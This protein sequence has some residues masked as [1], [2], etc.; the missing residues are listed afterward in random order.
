MSSEISILI[1]VQKILNNKTRFICIFVFS[2]R[3]MNVDAQQGKPVHSLSGAAIK[4]I[5]LNNYTYSTT[6]KSKGMLVYKSKLVYNR[7]SS[8]IEEVS[9]KLFSGQF[10][11]DSNIYKYSKEEKLSERENYERNEL[12]LK[13]VYKYNEQLKPIEIL[14]YYEGKPGGKETLTYDKVGTNTG[15][16]QYEKDGRMEFF[17]EYIY[18][19][20]GQM[21][22]EIKYRKDSSLWV[23]KTYSYDE[24]QNKIK[25]A[26]DNT[27]YKSTNLTLWEFDAKG[28][29]TNCKQFFDGKLATETHEGYD[30]NG[31]LITYSYLAS[32]ETIPLKKTLGGYKYNDKGD[33]V[34]RIQFNAKGDPVAIEERIIEYY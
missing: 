1:I 23:R 13:T 7:N 18:N 33:W 11:V 16:V 5:V 10:L 19:A 30:K 27:Y 6:N 29:Q 3:F 25:E 34:K 17:C 24:H 4:S 2:F 26:S 8:V 20:E 28:N 12:K 15:R 32:P 9:C 21:T 14:Y 22:E 31:D